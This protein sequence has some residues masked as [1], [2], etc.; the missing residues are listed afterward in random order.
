M[1][2][3][4]NVYVGRANVVFIEKKDFQKDLLFLQIHLKLVVMMLRK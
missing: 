3:I 1:E 2:D 4:N